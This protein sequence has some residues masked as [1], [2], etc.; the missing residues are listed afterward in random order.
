MSSSTI[1]KKKNVVDF[2]N[3]E[4]AFASKSNGELKKMSWLFRLMNKKWLVDYGSQLGLVAV[5]LRLPFV[6]TI[7][8]K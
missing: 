8:K 5:R 2:T 4:I 3:T 6:S 7:V 1:K